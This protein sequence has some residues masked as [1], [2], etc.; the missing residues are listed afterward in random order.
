MVFH[1]ILWVLQFALWPPWM[2]WWVALICD[3][4][5]TVHPDVLDVS[6]YLRRVCNIIIRVSGTWILQAITSGPYSCRIR[7][8][9]FRY[10]SP[11][12]WVLF[13]LYSSLRVKNITNCV[14][15]K[16]VR[17]LIALLFDQSTL[18]NKLSGYSLNFLNTLCKIYQIMN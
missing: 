9:M 14:V 11:R 13:Y 5:L 3:A 8:I 10:S 15:T 7:R 2:V 18:V 1:G 4:T 12:V 16:K 6:F 17:L